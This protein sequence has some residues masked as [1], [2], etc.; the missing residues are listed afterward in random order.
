MEDVIF[1]FFSNPAC[2]LFSV[3]IRTNVYSCAILSPVLLAPA[4]AD[5]HDGCNQTALWIP[6]DARCYIHEKK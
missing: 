2:V 6:L 5:S 4:V 1:Q 3:V